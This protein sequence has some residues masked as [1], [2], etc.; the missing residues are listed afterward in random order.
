V[1]GH[2]SYY[3]S[4]GDGDGAQRHDIANARNRR[5]RGSLGHL[6]VTSPQRVGAGRPAAVTEGAGRSRRGSALGA[7]QL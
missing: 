1:G 7:V 2:S 4:L 3:E 5:L 6:T